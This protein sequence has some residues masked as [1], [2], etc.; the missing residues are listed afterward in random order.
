MR[1]A[2]TPPT[3]PP[4][5]APAFELPPAGGGGAGDVVEDAMEE[6]VGVTEL[7]APEG[8]RI[9]PGGISGEPIKYVE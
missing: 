2:T 1:I 7:E 4:A 9:E 6:D 8:P 5:I 3:T